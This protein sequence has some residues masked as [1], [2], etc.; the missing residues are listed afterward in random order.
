TLETAGYRVLTVANGQAALD[1]V[2]AESP[3]LVILDLRMPILDGWEVCRRIR[4]FSAVPIIML[5]QM[6]DELDRVRG[7][8]SGA[9]DYLGK[10]FGQKEL[11]ARVR[12]ALRRAKDY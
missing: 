1:L 12:A 11:V 10:P 8:D 6:N 2:A 3:D 7:L 4:E 9:D 5:T